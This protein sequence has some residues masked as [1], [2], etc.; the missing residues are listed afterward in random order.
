MKAFSL[1]VSLTSLALCLSCANNNE[2]PSEKELDHNPGVIAKDSVLD[3]TKNAS[4][5]G[6]TITATHD[7]EK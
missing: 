2:S 5:T 3:A 6:S 4:D 1:F 7:H